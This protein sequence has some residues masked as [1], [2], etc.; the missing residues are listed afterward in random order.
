MEVG[1]ILR[2]AVT[3]SE[4]SAQ[5]DLKDLSQEG[6]LLE[7]PASSAALLTDGLLFEIEFC[8]PNG[9]RFTVKAV[10]R[11]KQADADRQTLKV[12]FKF[13]ACTADQERKLWFFVREIEREAKRYGEEADVGRLPSM[14]FQSQSAAVA[15]PV[16]RR[17]LLNYPTPMARRLA[18]VAGYLDA[19][20]LELQ[21][22]DEV[23]SVQL[24]R[25]ADML[26]QLAEEDIEALQFATRCW[27]RSRCWCATAWPWPCTCWRWPAATPCR[28]TCARRWRPAP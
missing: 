7:L 26:L 6:C 1:A 27:C 3:D 16:S 12:G 21:Q 20:L 22:G 10:P 14:L 19:Q 2:S 25:H 13:D 28:A 11:H 23:D 8:F 9:T 18:R 24:S 5:G 15:P 4:A 17:N